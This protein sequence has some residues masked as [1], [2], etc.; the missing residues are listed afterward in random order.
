MALEPYVVGLTVSGIAVLGVTLLPRLVSGRPISLPIF[1]VGLGVVVFSLPLGLPSPDPLEHGTVAEK[2]TEL[3]VI[4]ALMSAGLK[5]D[6]VPG[7]A[8]WTSTWRLLAVTMPISI[9]GAA[10]LGWGVAGFVV[11]AAALLGAVI[12]PTDP[13]LASEVQ[14]E[15][16]GEGEEGIAIDEKEGKADEVRF[17]LTS[18]AGLNDSLAFPFTYLAISMVALG[19]AP[20]NW[21]ETWLTEYVLYKIGVGLVGGVAAGVLLAR[22]I[23][24]LSA[25]TKLAQSVRGLEALGGT[26]FAYGATEIA[27][28]YGF[29]AVFVAALWIRNYEKRHEYNATLH[30][31]AEKGEQL[32]MT[33]IMVLFGGAIATGLFDP[34]TVR[35]AAVAATIVFVVRPAAGLVGLIGFARAWTEKAVISF[36]G[37]RGIG[38]FYYLSYGV[39]QAA[40]PAADRIWALVGCVVLVSVVVHGVAATPAVDTVKERVPGA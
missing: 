9:L 19:V 16:P 13:V 28:G 36:F 11:P 24:Q 12:A 30:D 21:L 37:I 26:L 14:V 29:L 4:L 39:N 17:A 35:D 18:E 20:E 3:G 2:L 22:L 34:L 25:E 6:R 38:S 33:L 40:F 10:L 7:V 5:L 15:E 27:G 31:V 8:S 32:L 1:Y 23:F